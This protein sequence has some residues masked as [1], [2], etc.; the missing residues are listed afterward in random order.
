MEVFYLASRQ[1]KALVPFSD[2]VDE[3]NFRLKGVN[4]RGRQ[5]LGKRYGA[6]IRAIWRLSPRLQDLRTCCISERMM[7]YFVLLWI[8]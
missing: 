3:L 5:L 7:I 4:Q 6:R 2:D 8:S 1:N